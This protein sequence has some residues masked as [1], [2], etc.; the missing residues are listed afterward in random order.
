LL[1]TRVSHQISCPAP[2][3]DVWSVLRDPHRW[4]E[5]EPFLARVEGAAG[6]AV[7]GQR[8]LGVARGWPLRIPLDVRRVV[9]RKALHVTVHTLP[10]LREDLEI[11]LVPATRGGTQIT[12]VARLSGPL[13][14]AAVLPLWFTSELTGRLLVRAAEKAQRQR[15]RDSSGVA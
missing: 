7:E 5:F 13:A 10:G 14:S 4:Q 9:P 1:P 15:L 8:L 6:H 3:P 11:V 2:P 12:F